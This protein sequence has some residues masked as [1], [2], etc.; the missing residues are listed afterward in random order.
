[1]PYR[2][3]VV[4]ILTASSLWYESHSGGVDR[5]FLHTNLVS[6]ICTQTVKIIDGKLFVWLLI[7]GGGVTPDERIVILPTQSW[8]FVHAFWSPELL[9]WVV[10]VFRRGHISRVIV[11][12]HLSLDLG[13]WKAQITIGESILDLVRAQL[14]QSDRLSFCVL[15]VPILGNR[16]HRE[17]VF[18]ETV[19]GLRKHKLV[20]ARKFLRVWWLKGL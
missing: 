4:T 7:D 18:H 5:N 8:T 6:D 3:V 13:S 14:R 17:D 2:I 9:Y 15:I 10:E 20:L 19:V 16:V 11:F 1:M 12:Y